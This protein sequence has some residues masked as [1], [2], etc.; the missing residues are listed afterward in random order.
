MRRISFLSAAVL[1]CGGTAASCHGTRRRAWQQHAVHH[2]DGHHGRRQAGHLVLTGVA[3]RQKFFLNVYA[4]GSYVIEGASVHT[5]EELAA[6]DQPKQLHLVMERDVDGKDMAEALLVAIR[7]NYPVPAFNDEV[8]RL[9][10]MLRDIDLKKG[11]HIYLTHLPGVGCAATSST[12]AISPS[13]IRS[14]H[15]RFGTFIS[16]KQRRRRD[17]EG[18]VSRLK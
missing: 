11:D 12:R 10:E 18:L 8:N 5:A 14:S 7:Q 17:Q 3:L 2:D 4:I 13:R 15:G 9:T 1:L 6:I 16:A